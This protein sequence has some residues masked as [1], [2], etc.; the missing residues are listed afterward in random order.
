MTLVANNPN[1]E[2][3]GAVQVG[4]NIN[5]LSVEQAETPAGKTALTNSIADAAKVQPSQVSITSITAVSN[6]RMRMLSAQINVVFTIVLANLAQANLLET[7]IR[8]NT[9]ALAVAMVSSLRAANPTTFAA[10]VI[11]VT[12][13]SSGVTVVAVQ[14]V[15]K[16]SGLSAGAIVGIVIGVIGAVVLL[17]VAMVIAKRRGMLKMPRRKTGTVVPHDSSAPL[18]A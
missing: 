14:P 4:V 3:K 15:A 7:S 2:V 10:V 11:G 13:T 9:T 12:Q 5:G 17:A 18:Q 16:S 1:V 8:T 6:R